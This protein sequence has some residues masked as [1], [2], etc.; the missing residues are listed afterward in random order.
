MERRGSSPG[1]TGYGLNK[2]PNSS[3]WGLPE[4]HSKAAPSPYPRTGARRFLEDP[5]TVLLAQPGYSPTST[6]FGPSKDPNSSGRVSR[7]HRRWAFRSRF[8][9]TEIRQLWVTTR[10]ILP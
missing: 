8:P 7:V 5:Q 9:R 2:G 3:A 6:A 4:E 10:T 1:P